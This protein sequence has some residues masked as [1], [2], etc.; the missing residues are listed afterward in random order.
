MNF[1]WSIYHEILGNA[2]FYFFK[3]HQTILRDIETIFSTLNVCSIHFLDTSIF[4]YSPKWLYFFTNRLININQN[5]RRF[6][7]HTKTPRIYLSDSIFDNF[8]N[9][10]TR[11]TVFSRNSRFHAQVIL[12]VISSLF[13]QCIILLCT[14]HGFYR[15]FVYRNAL[16]PW[17][18]M[19]LSF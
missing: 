5:V 8:D 1:G 2:I 17:T 18:T 11:L 10:C 15:A 3:S 16:I 14:I 6:F 19:K 7:V 4:T 9:N 12:T 13:I